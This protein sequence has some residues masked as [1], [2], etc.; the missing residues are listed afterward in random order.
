[1]RTYPKFNVGDKVRRIVQADAP[2][3]A[4]GVYTV[5]AVDGLWIGVAEIPAGHD[6]T[7]YAAPAFERVV[8]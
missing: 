6:T 5:S 7:P 8:E 1:M 4:G 3:W 2:L